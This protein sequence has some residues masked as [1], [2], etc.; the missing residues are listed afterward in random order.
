[1]PSSA[2]T[3]HAAND[4]RLDLIFHA[5]A[6]RT[7]RAL[8]ARL[9]A[10]PAAITVLGEPFDMSRPAVS[11]HLRVLEEAGL[12]ARTIEGRTHLCAIDGRQLHDVERW[13]AGYRA[14]WSDNLRSLARIVEKPPRRGRRR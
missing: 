11:K 2:R 6:D 7:R 13:L 3:T 4:D 14:F 5:L 1:M 8:L 12:I 9:A 10:G